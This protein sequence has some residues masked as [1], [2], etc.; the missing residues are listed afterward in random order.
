MS[1]E[2]LSK[3]ADSDNIVKSIVSGYPDPSKN[4]QEISEKIVEAYKAAGI[5]PDK[6]DSNVVRF[7]NEMS[8]KSQTSLT[9]CKT[10]RTPQ[11]ITFDDIAGQE[12]AKRQLRTNYIYPMLYP[13]LFLNKPKGVLLYGPPGTGKTLLVK[14]ATASIPNVLFFSPSPGEL[15]GKYEG[16]TEKNIFTVFDCAAQ[17]LDEEKRKDPNTKVN[18]SIIF[19]DEFDSVAGTR[20]DDPSMRRSVNALLQA[21]DGLNSD[22][23][24]TLI[25]ATNYPWDLDDAILRRFTSKIFVDLPDARARKWLILSEVVKNFSLPTSLTEDKTKEDIKNKI[26]NLMNN[27]GSLGSSAEKS[28]DLIRKYTV[29][30]S[31]EGSFVDESFVESVVNTTGLNSDAKKVT[32]RISNGTYVDPDTIA[33]S[34]K[35]GYSASDIT[36]MMTIAIQRASLRALN[37]NFLGVSENLTT[38][39]TN[40]TY[41][42][43][44]ETG[45]FS[46]EEVF[47]NPE[48][49]E[50]CINFVFCEEDIAEGIDEY[51]STIKPDNYVR[52][53]NYAHLGI[54]P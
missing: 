46:P 32:D 54:S 19:I 14:A 35:F 43:S 37:R 34:I 53:L 31:C 16:E 48:L 22:P 27:D 23:R 20:G 3:A 2:L 1:V 15:K 42:V 38:V 50:K 17:A 40:P 52:L 30:G 47:N 18:A 29:S 7:L 12:F 28:F 44:S 24:V 21:I 6:L 45:S 26:K 8:K 10:P 51:P 13:K 25:A 4:L 5:G 9:D 49:R 36:N 11:D 39:K 41:L 33:A